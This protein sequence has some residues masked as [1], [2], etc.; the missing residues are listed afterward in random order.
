LIR[1]RKHEITG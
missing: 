1:T